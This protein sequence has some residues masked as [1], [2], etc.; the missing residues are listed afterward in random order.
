MQNKSITQQKIAQG[1]GAGLLLGVLIWITLMWAGSIAVRSS[2]E[3]VDYQVA[4]YKLRLTTISKHTTSRG[5]VATVELK[6]GLLWHELGCMGMGAMTGW[7]L[8][9]R[10][11][12]T[13][14]K[15]QEDRFHSRN[16]QEDF[17]RDRS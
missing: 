10:R 5:Q 15:L 2:A 6:S 7:L 8:S 9:K 4:V 16:E 1:A 11:G 12:T 3:G 17:D 14:G 13:V